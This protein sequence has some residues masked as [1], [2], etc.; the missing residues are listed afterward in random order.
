[1][2]P[3]SLIALAGLAVLVTACGGSD[4]K[5]PT[6]PGGNNDNSSYTAS[7]SG[8]YTKSLT[9]K[10]A[11][12]SDNSDNEVGFVLALGTE[13][14]DNGDA[15]LIWRAQAGVLSAGTY[16]FADFANTEGDIPATQFAG[17]LVFSLTGENS[18]LCS[19]TSGTLTVTQSSASRLKGSIN[20]QASCIDVSSSSE[21]TITMTGNFDAIGGTVTFPNG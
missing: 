15:M 20:A 13:D 7:I 8:G 1:M 3:R 9:G 2:N 16:Q 18:A 5:S 11:F 21:K 12:A 4:S 17:T 19:V 6:E 10:S 14:E